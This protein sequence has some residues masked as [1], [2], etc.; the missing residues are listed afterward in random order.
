MKTFFVVEAHIKRNHF[1][2][3][4][5]PEGELYGRDH[6]D[7]WAKNNLTFWGMPM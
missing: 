1:F 3:L 7:F 5:F 4:N 2:A 6:K